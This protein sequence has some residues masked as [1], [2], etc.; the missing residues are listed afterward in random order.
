MK[1][2]RRFRGTWDTEV[3]AAYI[4]FRR[5]RDGEAVGNIVIEDKRLKGMVVLDLDA[6]NR[7]IGIEFI[8]AKK[9]LGDDFLKLHE[10]R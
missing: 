9:L 2:L 7:V 1:K 8:G 10:K 3:D 4:Y 6:R 5:I